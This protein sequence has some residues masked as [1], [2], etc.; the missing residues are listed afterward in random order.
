[1]DGPLL[2]VFREV[3]GKSSTAK[4]LSYLSLALLSLILRLAPPNDR[5]IEESIEA[6][7]QP[8]QSALLAS[9]SPLALSTLSLL[10]QRSAALA[11]TFVEYNG[12][13]QL[14]EEGHHP[15]EELLQIA[16]VVMM[17]LPYY[18]PAE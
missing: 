9:K 14:L 5:K 2:Y 8:I 3:L 18:T 1:L 6:D 17:K 13:K 7:W 10:V 16:A 12:L 15:P 11:R 4:G